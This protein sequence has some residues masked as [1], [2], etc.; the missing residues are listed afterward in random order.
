MRPTRWS[1]LLALPILLLAAC[2]DSAPPRAPRPS[3]LLFT[4]KVPGSLVVDTSGTEDAE[5]L[6]MVVPTSADSVARYLRATIGRAGWRLQNDRTDGP[7]TDLYASDGPFATG[8]LWI[9][10]EAQDSL[11]ARYTMIATL[12]PDSAA[13][14]GAPAGGT[15]RA[16]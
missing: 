12:R 2:R 9:H 13:R 10:I 4:P 6:V 3:A 5:R 1:G 15:P 14:P 11:S 8:S 16:Y 7:I